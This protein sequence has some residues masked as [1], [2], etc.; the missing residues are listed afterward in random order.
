MRAHLVIGFVASL[1]SA[2]CVDGVTPDCSDAA[3]GCG[4]SLDGSTGEASSGD[5]G[6]SDASGDAPKDSPAAQ[7]AQT[8]TGL[9]AALDAQGD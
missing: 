1:V 6:A 3:A 9:D 7:D 5:G 8:D 2:A 4:P